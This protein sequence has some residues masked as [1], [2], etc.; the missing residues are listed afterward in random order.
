MDRT[1][2]MGRLAVARGRADRRIFPLVEGAWMVET[3]P[4]P[5]NRRWG[6]YRVRVPGT[7]RAFTVGWLN[8]HVPTPLRWWWRRTR[9]Y[10][11]WWEHSDHPQAGCVMDAES[12]GCA[13]Q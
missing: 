5:L 13:D 4:A 9:L 3:D 1:W 2:T 11:W 6:G 10:R 7:D 8:A 12:N